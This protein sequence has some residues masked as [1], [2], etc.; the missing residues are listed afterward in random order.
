MSFGGILFAAIALILLGGCGL[1]AYE[2]FCIFTG[3]DPT[4]SRIVAYTFSTNQ[5][6]YMVGVF[7]AGVVLGSLITHFTNWS[8]V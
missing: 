8:A 5:H 7:I 6:L 4:I 3:K 1:C 2:S